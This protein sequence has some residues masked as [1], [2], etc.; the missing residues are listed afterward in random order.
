MYYIKGTSDKESENTIDKVLVLF[1]FIQGK[2]V[3][4]AFYKGIELGS[5]IIML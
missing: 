2:G 1:R 4:E 5:M 3:F